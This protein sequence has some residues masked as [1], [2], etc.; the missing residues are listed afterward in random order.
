MTEYQRP[1]FLMGI[2]RDEH[3]RPIDYGNRWAGASP[4]EDAYSRVSNLQRFLPMH[5]VAMAL[6]RQDARARR[7]HHAGSR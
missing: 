7:L 2:Y 6:I 4:P 5:A 3:G 1:T